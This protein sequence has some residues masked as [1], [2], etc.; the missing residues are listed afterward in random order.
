[1]SSQALTVRHRILDPMYS[2]VRDCTQLN[3]YTILARKH[4][5]I[6]SLQLQND[7]IVKVLPRI[8]F[9]PKCGKYLPNKSLISDF[10][11]MDWWSK[12]GNEI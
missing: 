8:I 6:A 11:L 3:E 4:T 10:I 1:M 12:K 9:T 7:P 5:G 2:G